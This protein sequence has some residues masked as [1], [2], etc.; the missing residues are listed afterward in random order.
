MTWYPDGEGDFKRS[1]KQLH[2]RVTELV[3]ALNVM[4]ELNLGLCGPA[5]KKP[6]GGKIVYGHNFDW[7]QFKV[8][9]EII[10]NNIENYR[11]D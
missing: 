8:I 7:T 11:T 6:K 5:D 2:Q 10:I 3:R 1:N 4:E 9:F